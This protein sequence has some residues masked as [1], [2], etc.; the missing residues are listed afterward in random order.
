MTRPDAHL[1]RSL[2][3]VGFH[4]RKSI[5]ILILDM[6]S[7]SPQATVY[8]GRT[9]L[10]VDF[11]FDLRPETKNGRRMDGQIKIKTKIKTRVKG[12]GQECPSHISLCAH[13]LSHCR[14]VHFSR[15]LRK[16]GFHGRKSIGVL[17]LDMGS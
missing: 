5:G 13:S 17:I 4:E 7:Q 11:G 1:T 14:V 12:D 3:K 10:S 15:S 8:V 6:G 9:L 2:R 16:V